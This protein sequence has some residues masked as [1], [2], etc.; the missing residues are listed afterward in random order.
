MDVCNAS[1]SIRRELLL[2]LF[3]VFALSVQNVFRSAFADILKMHWL[4]GC[5]NVEF[6]ECFV[7]GVQRCVAHCAVIVIR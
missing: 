6:C 3:C 4:V 2:R 5:I 7:S 1:H